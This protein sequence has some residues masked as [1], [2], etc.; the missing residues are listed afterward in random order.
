M[1]QLRLFIVG[2]MTYFFSL[3]AVAAIPG[4]EDPS[5]GAAT[6]IFAFGSNWVKDIIGFGVPT[7]LGLVLLWMVWELWAKINE[8]RMSKE[9]AWNG[10]IAFGGAS[11]AYFIVAVFIATKITTIYA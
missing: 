3:F 1:K 11:V 7:V 4:V 2:F 10:V 9:P 6:G 5:S 8:Q